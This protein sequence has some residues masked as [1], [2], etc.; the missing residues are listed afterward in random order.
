MLIGLNDENPMFHNVYEF[1]LLT[2][3]MQRIFHNERFPS[4]ITVDNDMNI[5]LVQEEA[6][7][8]SMVYYK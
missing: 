3:Q 4:Q 8:G 5:R 7:D 6:D 2:N 1:D